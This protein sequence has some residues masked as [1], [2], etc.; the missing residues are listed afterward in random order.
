MS[1][2]HRLPL[3]CVTNIVMV[4]S[5]SKYPLCI[6]IPSVTLVEQLTNGSRVYFRETINIILL[7]LSNPQTT[8]APS[9]FV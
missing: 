2:S 3:C 7:I 9:M 1:V 6:K 5:S 4:A 8:R